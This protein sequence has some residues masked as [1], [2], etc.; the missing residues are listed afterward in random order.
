MR[1]EFRIVTTS[2]K[3]VEKSFR[4]TKQIECYITSSNRLP[5]KH[6]KTLC[7]FLDEQNYVQVTGVKFQVIRRDLGREEA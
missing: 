2:D 5:Q 6:K 7:D 4:A 3:L 1:V